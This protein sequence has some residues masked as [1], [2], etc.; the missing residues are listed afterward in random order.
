MSAFKIVQNIETVAVSSTGIST[1]SPIPLRSGYLKISSDENVYVELSPTP[2]LSTSSL[3]IAAGET[4]ILKETVTSQRLVG[5]ATGTTTHLY[6]P[7]GT[8]SDFAIGD[9]VQV[10]GIGYTSDLNTDF[11]EVISVDTTQGID[12]W[13]SRKIEIDFDTS[14]IVYPLEYT[15]GSK[16]YSQDP[17]L[18]WGAGDGPPLSTYPS[19]STVPYSAEVRRVI[20]LGAMGDGTAANVHITEIQ[21]AGG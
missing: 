9:Y 7:E 19:D 15:P 17:N 6:L 1:S 21:I 10:T 14:A 11:A 8:F 13:Y 12:G 18:L 2:T 4:I 16:D 20:K 5:I 3:W